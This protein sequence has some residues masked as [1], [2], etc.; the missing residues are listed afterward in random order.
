[1]NSITRLIKIGDKIKTNF[2]K[3][4]ATKAEQLKSPYMSCHGQP[5][6]KKIIIENNF[7]CPECNEHHKLEPH[8]Y[9]D[10]IFFGKAVTC[11]AAAYCIKHRDKIENIFMVAHEDHR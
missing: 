8:Q 9:Y 6:L 10:D 7:V 3:T 2:K 4:M 1:M 5:I 11:M